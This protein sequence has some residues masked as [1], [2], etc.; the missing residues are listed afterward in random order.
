[1]IRLQKIILQQRRNINFNKP[2]M[3]FDNLI[4]INELFDSSKRPNYSYILKVVKCIE[5]H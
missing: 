2:T 3:E 4:G 1:M 5:T